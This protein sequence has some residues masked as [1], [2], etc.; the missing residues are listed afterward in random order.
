MPSEIFCPNCWQNRG[1][2]RKTSEAVDRV[3]YA[4]TM[5]LVVL[6]AAGLIYLVVAGLFGW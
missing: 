4:L 3:R 5:I 2:V 1:V 6:I